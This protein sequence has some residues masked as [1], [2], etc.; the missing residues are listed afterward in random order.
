[1]ML[2]ALSSR[3]F[4]GTP[5]A[6]SQLRLGL[7]LPPLRVWHWL[8][9][10]LCLLTGSGLNLYRLAWRPA[11]E[12]QAYRGFYVPDG[13][14]QGETVR[15]ARAYS[16]VEAPLCHWT[17]LRWRIDLI[18]PPAAGTAGAS[19][20]IHINDVRMRRVTAGA[21]WQTIEL[22]S[23]V[24]SAGDVTLQFYSTLYGDDDHGIGVGRITMEP[25][26][27][28][29]NVFQAGVP[30][31]IIGAIVW[32][33]CLVRLDNGS[34]TETD[35]AAAATADATTVRTSR[36]RIG[37]ALG[38]LVIVWAYLGIWALLKPPFQ[39]PDEPQHLLRA[40]SVRLQPW[41]SRTP[42]TLTLDPQF[43]NPFVYQPPVNIGQLYF[44]S[45][46]QL[47]M[48][49]IA[50]LKAI[51]WRPSWPPLPPFRTPLA[52]YP[53]TYYGSVFG[54]A[55]ATTS[56]WHLSPYQSTYA[57]RA[58]TVV[59]AGLLWIAVWRALQMTPGVERHAGA[60]FAF[61]LI[62][63]MLA[64]VSSS[65]TPDSVNVP[66][67]TLA[68]LLMYRT[69]STGRGAWLTTAALVACGLTKPTFLLVLGSLPLPMLLAW[70]ARTIPTR[71]LI[72]ATLAAVRAGVIAFIAFYA[73]SPPRFFAGNIPKEISLASY[74]AYYVDR[75]PF[76]WRS[77]W[78]V[79]GWLDYELHGA[80][81][82]AL[83]V[84]VVAIAFLV[85][86][87]T[88]EEA[89][90][91]R[92]VAWLGVSYL[93]LMTFGEYWYLGAAGYNFQGR[94]LLPAGIALAGL[95]LHANKYARWSLLG[96]VLVMHALL[97]HMTI[98]RY[99]SDG[100]AGLWASLPLSP[101]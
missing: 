8:A 62:N 40:A 68:V 64:F 45:A 28:T 43:L 101:S 31:A 48:T 42:D 10:A 83:F 77:Y 93:V 94:H 49:D 69:L 61:L 16:K 80:W 99:F 50:I 85:R 2:G 27:T 95:V 54:L 6:L 21:G 100:L 52:T 4:T 38:L 11:G 96:L 39:A 3:F 89:R 63:P 71:H 32:L 34:A 76:I 51:P 47:S 82:F 24:P 58:W 70:R 84:V 15:W 56:A 91:T 22:L 17:P 9:L 18:A 14:V 25:V 59:F 60:L 92:F 73:W 5:S 86:A 78:G 37:P 74:A 65:V 66:L 53:T 26:F 75:L 30:G 57:Y 72:A 36:W 55:E 1:M 81:Y 67:A 87:R 88:P 98:T 44:T 41:A 29:W 35:A 20:V 90:F 97:M 46:N 7:A 13:I 19:T 33:L 23:D 79:L 12:L